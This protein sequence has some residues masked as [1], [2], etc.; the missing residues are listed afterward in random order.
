MKLK[1]TSA[2]AYLKESANVQCLFF[3]RFLI[4][5]PLFCSTVNCDI[6]ENQINVKFYRIP[7]ELHFTL[8]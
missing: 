1:N 7:V 6:K 2:Q 4:E 3:I 8:I 5:I